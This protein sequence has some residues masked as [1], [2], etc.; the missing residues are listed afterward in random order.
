MYIYFVCSMP[1]SIVDFADGNILYIFN[2]CITI[3][4]LIYLIS[5]YELIFNRGVTLRLSLKFLL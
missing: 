4:I 2:M 3:N 5:Y 1:D